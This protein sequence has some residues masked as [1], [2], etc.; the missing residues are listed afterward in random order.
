MKQFLSHFTMTPSLPTC[1][2]KRLESVMF[3]A[4]ISDNQDGYKPQGQAQI[5]LG[6]CPRMERCQSV[7]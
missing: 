7:R 1:E 5:G 2:K 3:V 6:G 4:E